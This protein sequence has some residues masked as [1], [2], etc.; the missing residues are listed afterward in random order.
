M[1]LGVD[2]G[3]LAGRL[4]HGSDSCQK[5]AQRH[6]VAVC[7]VFTNFTPANLGVDITWQY[8]SLVQLPLSLFAE[9]VRILT[10]DDFRMFLFGEI[11]TDLLGSEP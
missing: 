1:A 6:L 11:S 3:C 5:L 10:F 8:F 9:D 2:A 4:A 7:A